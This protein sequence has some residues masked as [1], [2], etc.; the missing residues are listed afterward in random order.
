VV[1]FGQVAVV[2]LVFKYLLSFVFQVAFPG[3]V[4]LALVFLKA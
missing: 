3:S 4:F 1:G 2:L